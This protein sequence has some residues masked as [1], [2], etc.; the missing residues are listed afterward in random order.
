MNFRKH[1]SDQL[2]KS[3]HGDT[4][5]ILEIDVTDQSK[6]IT[7]FPSSI[8]EMKNIEVTVSS[9]RYNTELDYYST[10]FICRIYD[11]DK[12]L[13]TTDHIPNIQLTMYIEKKIVLE[14]EEF[15][16]SVILKYD[17]IIE[18]KLVESKIEYDTGPIPV[19]DLKIY[20][21]GPIPVSDLKI[22]D[23][24]NSTSDEDFNDIK[25]F[26]ACCELSRMNYRGICGNNKFIQFVDTCNFCDDDIKPNYQPI[27]YLNTPKKISS[28]ATIAVNQSVKK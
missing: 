14:F 26:R 4:K 15:I 17:A 25:I 3:N 5:A 18:R 12:L 13:S 7:I 1:F 22:Y 8:D 6:T 11:N 24:S 27:W 19:S 23:T 2:I 10:K 9:T 16:K 20:D 21:T 28:Y